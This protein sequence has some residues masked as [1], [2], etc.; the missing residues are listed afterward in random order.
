MKKKVFIIIPALMLAMASFSGCEQ[1]ELSCCK[2]EN[3]TVYVNIKDTVYITEFDKQKD[4][5]MNLLCNKWK[6]VE[7]VDE[8]NG[9]RTVPEGIDWEGSYT[10][11]FYKD[12]SCAGATCGNSFS[13][14]YMLDVSR[15]LGANNIFAIHLY[16]SFITDAG[17]CYNSENAYF[18]SEHLLRN[19]ISF[20]VTEDSLKLHYGVESFF[21]FLYKKFNSQ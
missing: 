11:S 9:T 10:I 12:L 15:Y 3:D 6:L 17:E 14:R 8:W 19:I 18:Y 20:T 13:S 1:K 4:S 16:D 2:W 5:I 7:F 21:Y